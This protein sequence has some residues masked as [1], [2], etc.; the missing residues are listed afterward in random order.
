M[1]KQVCLEEDFPLGTQTLTYQLL[2]TACLCPPNSYSK[3]L[4]PS[5]MVLGK[6]PLGG[7]QVR[8]ADPT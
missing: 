6:G 3:I 5:V 8:R 1:Y 7:E 4:T 2:W